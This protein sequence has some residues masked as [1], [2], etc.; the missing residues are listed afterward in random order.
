MQLWHMNDKQPAQVCLLYCL[1]V[2]LY[3]FFP[4]QHG[5]MAALTHNTLWK[6]SSP[7][8]RNMRKIRKKNV[9]NKIVSTGTVPHGTYTAP[10]PGTR[11]Q[12]E[13]LLL[14]CPPQLMYFHPG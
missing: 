12:L 3:G 13:A 4:Q 7:L 11:D 2:V 10:R 6:G 1:I 14:G 5:M 8:I 9:T